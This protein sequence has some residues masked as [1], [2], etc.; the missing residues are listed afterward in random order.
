MPESDQARWFH[1]EV[2]PH[3]PLLRAYL[4]KQ[5]PALPDVDDIVQESHL[6]LLKARRHGSVASAKSYLFAIARN[7]TLGVFRRR[8]HFTEI[9]VND[10]EGWRILES[11]TDVAESASLSQEV[12]LA[13]DAIEALPAR[14]RE[15]VILR[16]LR[17]LSHREIATQLGL[18]E[19]TVRVQVARGMK[20]CAQFLRERGVIRG[21]P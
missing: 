19:A 20:K 16:A 17:G 18:S 15:I 4:H 9:P 7:V 10:L 1:E 3:E 14:C 5:F 6:R 12:A 8:Q 11:D 2:H 21:R 13:T